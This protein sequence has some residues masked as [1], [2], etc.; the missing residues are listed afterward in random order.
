MSIICELVSYQSGLVKGL[1]RYLIYVYFNCSH[2]C[3][4]IEWHKGLSWKI[5]IIGYNARRSPKG[6]LLLIINDVKVRLINKLNEND[7][8][9]KDN[10][11]IN[12][13]MI[14]CLLKYDYVG[15]IID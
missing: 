4:A 15:I 8:I 10:I 5:E 11:H 12:L 14:D 7:C 9:S 6:E 13:T 1:I 3:D 2:L